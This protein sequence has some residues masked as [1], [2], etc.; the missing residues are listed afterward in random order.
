MPETIALLALVTLQRLVELVW[1]RRNENRLRARGA[2]EVGAAHYPLIVALHASWLASLWVAGWDRPL[3]WPFAIAFL[4]VQL[5]RAWVFM[6]LGSRWTARVLVVPGETLVRRG[7]YRF[8]RHP[9][10]L[11]VS[12]EMMFLPLALGLPAFAIG[13]G[14]ANLLVLWW[15]I[16]VESRALA[17]V[18]GT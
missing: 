7:P 5:G 4:V 11:V 6:T 16:R 3:D 17:A 9:N 13:F 8:V 10:Y 12:L 18:A 15:R 2:I 14:V 1:S